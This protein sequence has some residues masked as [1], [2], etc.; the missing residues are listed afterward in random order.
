MNPI[1]L[2]LLAAAAGGV[3][4]SLV[5]YKLNYNLIDTLLDVVRS[6]EAKVARLKLV[7]DAANKRVLAAALAIKKAI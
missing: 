6:A 1:V 2:A 5:E 4:T 7:A 3:I